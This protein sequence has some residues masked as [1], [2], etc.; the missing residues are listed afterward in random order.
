VH[1]NPDFQ[2]R[3]AFTFRARIAM[4]MGA[5]NMT[6]TEVQTGR[7]IGSCPLAAMLPD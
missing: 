2:Q 3:Y 5:K 4:T 7:R 1:P 6:M